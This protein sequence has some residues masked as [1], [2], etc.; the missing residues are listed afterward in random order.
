MAVKD[1]GNAYKTKPQGGYA[2]PGLCKRVEVE[3]AKT[4]K[5]KIRGNK[6]EDRPLLDKFITH[7]NVIRGIASGVFEDL[8]PWP[9]VGYQQRVDFG[10]DF[11]IGCEDELIRKA[12][13][14]VDLSRDSAA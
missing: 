9:L 11:S 14:T 13:G 5:L 7:H 2:E 8:Y 3:R 12:V 10:H 4:P 1:L 6:R